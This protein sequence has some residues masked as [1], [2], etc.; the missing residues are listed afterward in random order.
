[1]AIATASLNL[2]AFPQH[3]DGAGLT[4]RFLCLPQGNPREPLQPGLIS[5][6]DANLQFEARL[7]GSLDHLPRAADALPVGPLPLDEPPEQKAALFAE[8]EE[9]QFKIKPEEPPPPVAPPTPSFRKAVTASYRELVGNRQLSRWLTE[10]KDYECALHAARDAQPLEPEVLSDELAWG[11]LLAFALR[12]P[13][14]ATALGLIGQT[15]VVPADADFYARGGW[16]HIGLHASGDLADDP[17]LVSSFAARIP[18][19]AANAERYVYAALLFPVDD[20]GVADEAFHDAERYDR[21]FAR[22]VHAAQG[23]EDGD[24]IRLAWDDEQI[25]EAFARQVAATSSRPMGTAGFRVDVQDAEGDG[26]WHSLERVTSLDDLKLGELVIGR[27]EGEAVVEV[28]PVQPSP[29]LPT[30]F[31]MPPYFC[32]WRGSSLVLT[33]PDLTRLHQR[34]DFDP[35]FDSMRLGREKTFAPVGDKDV[36]L[37]YGHSYRFRVRLA[38]LSYG[39]PDFGVETPDEPDADAHHTVE[40]AFQRHRPPGAIQVMERPTR[41]NPRVLIA[42]PQ[43]RHPELLYTGAHTFADLEAALDE[44]VAAYREREPSLPDPDVLEVAIRLEVRALKGDRAPWLLLYET[45]REFDAAEL[46]LELETQD[47]ATLARFAKR[48]PHVG[49]LLVPTARDLRLVLVALGRNDPGYFASDDARYGAPVSVEIRAA[50]RHRRRVLRRR[51]TQLTSFFFRQVGSDEAVQRPLARLAQELDFGGSE[52]T[53]TGPSGHRT[54][55]GCANALRHILSPERS[56]LTLASDADLS[57]RWINVLQFELGRDWTWDDLAE[58]GLTVQRRL[59]RPGLY[60]EVEIAG[61]VSVPRT[62]TPAMLIGVGDSAR[63]PER[64]FSR[65]V[66][67]DAVDPKPKPCEFPSELTVSY[68]IAAT[69]RGDLPPP[70]IVRTA[71]LLPITTPPVQVP[72]LVSAGIALSPH[73]PADDYSATNQRERML[74]LEFDALPADPKD[75]YFVR[76]LASAADPLLLTDEADEAIAELVPE[77]ALPLD[78]ERMRVI[79]PKQPRDDNGL[80]AMQP[81]L[82]RSDDGAH[83]LIPLPDGLEASSPEL[84]NMFTY[85]VRLGH[86]DERWSTAH[87]RFGPPLRV[88]GVQ[89]PPPPLVCQAARGGDVSIPPGETILVRAAFATPVQGGRHVRPPKPLTRL[90]AL[91]Y[92]RVEQADAVAWR[93]LLLLRT[94]L[95]PPFF[96]PHLPPPGE[97]QPPLLYGEGEFSLGEVRRILQRRGL[98]DAAPLT[99]LVAEFHTQPEIEDPL[100]TH[101][102]HARM[103]RVSPLVSIPDAC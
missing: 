79:T 82:R 4:V 54:I 55:F 61:T 14:L 93:N 35:A 42:K 64:S 38:D 81:L 65:V 40:V 102:G 103:L 66:F 29:A 22:L 88:A 13:K 67:V 16:L 83:F 2:L 44:D 60:D 10:E 95:L 3:W 25:A 62:L 48:P 75:T 7:I 30:D 85:E 52:L 63:A 70:D 101:L 49:P 37:L 94:P 27:Y 53:L 76:V 73:E 78:D 58:E 36:P 21:G 68:E 34:P 33:D 71:V 92:A 41:E 97:T 80:R 17:A 39:G 56:S 8:L 86:T 15:R 11:E 87:G 32:T 1:M 84:F 74:W 9:N 24:G 45:T 91:L 77:P 18:P 28:V 43:L 99:A 23:D 72:H 96:D 31:W 57:Q 69:L 89:H 6:A 100:G 90:W 19:L 59:S 50:T 12:Q 46:T 47:V 26:T 5:F 51:A 98:A 20:A